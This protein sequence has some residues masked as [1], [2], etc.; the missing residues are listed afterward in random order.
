MQN[1]YISKSQMSD[2]GTEDFLSLVLPDTGYYFI[3]TPNPGGP[4]FKHYPL[5]TIPEMVAKAN[6]LNDARQNVY[7]ACASY[8]NESYIGK[9]GKRHWRTG[10][11]AGWAKTFWCEI[12]CGA[13]KA[14]EGKG[15]ETLKQAA[16][17]LKA[18][19]LANAVPIPTVVKSG[20]GLHCYWV[21][22]ET[23]TKESWLPVAFKFKMLAK[24]GRAP[25]L[26]DPSRT[27]DIASVL[28][29]IGTNNWKPSRAGAKVILHR[30]MDPMDFTDF[31]SAIEVAH[32]QMLAD[33][34]P[35]QKN[36]AT[37]YDGPGLAIEH[38]AGML[39]HINPDIARDEWWGLLHGE[40]PLTEM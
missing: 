22:T 23:I 20:G 28:R 37:P 7:F 18:F 3:A 19:C 1:N 12:D 29:P 16:T 24:E 11:N 5:N 33:K 40:F 10:L 17:A 39:E 8:L 30:T 4:G 26:A 15:Y 35:T 6:E 21:F 31:Q 2:H 9:D 25:L 32:A 14:A 13:D 36:D 27:A 38:L 34:L